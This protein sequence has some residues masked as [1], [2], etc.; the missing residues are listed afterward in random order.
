MANTFLQ[1]FRNS[2]LPRDGAHAAKLLPALFTS[3]CESW[4][5]GIVRFA[6]LNPGTGIASAVQSVPGGPNVVPALALTRSALFALGELAEQF[7][8]ELP[9]SKVPKEFLVLAPGIYGR[10]ITLK[11]ARLECKRING[12]TTPSQMVAYRVPVD[13]WVDD[14]GGI[15]W[16]GT[17]DEG[18]RIGEV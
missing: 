14:M 15:R 13:A 2:F 12:G 6:A 16:P 3:I 11:A 17:N 18:E 7:K 5:D 1:H 10:G 9:R 8:V 4:P